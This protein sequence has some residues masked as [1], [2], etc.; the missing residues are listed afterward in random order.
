MNTTAFLPLNSDGKEVC[1]LLRKAF[2]AGVL[3]AIGESPTTG[4]ENNIIWNGVELKTS[5]SGGPARYSIMQKIIEASFGDIKCLRN[6]RNLTKFQFRLF[7]R[8]CS[9]LSS[10]A[11]TEDQLIN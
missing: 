6:F 11:L 5:K 3:F 9:L 4:E 2:D 8:P 1:C 7:L 10:V